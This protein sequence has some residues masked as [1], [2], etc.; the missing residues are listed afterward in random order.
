MESKEAQERDRKQYQQA[1][2]PFA[3]GALSSYAEWHQQH[4]KQLRSRALWQQYFKQIDVF[5]VPCSFTVAIHHDHKE[6]HS[7][8][9]IDTPDGR[10]PYTQ[11]LPWMV[12]ASLTGCPATIAPVGRTGAGLPVGIQIM[13]P[14]WEDATPIQFAD[15]LGREIG[16][17]EPPPGYEVPENPMHDAIIVGARCAGAPLAMLLSRKGHRVLLI[18]KASFPSDRISTHFIMQ[19]GLARVKRWGLL[20]KIR[21]LG[22][23]PLRRGRM[24]AGDCEFLGYPPPISGIDYGLAPRRTRLD[25]LLID[26]AVCSG[27][28]LREGFHVDGVLTGANRVTGVYGRSRGGSRIAEHA[29]IVVGADGPASVIA[30]TICACK[31][32]EQLSA[33]GAYY[34]YWGGAPP[35][36]DFEMYVRHGYGGVMFPTNDGLTC[37]VGGWRDEAFGPKRSPA[38]AYRAFMQAIPRLS[39]VLS[40][41]KQIEPLKG[42]Q[43]L[44]GYFRQSWGPGWALAGDAEYHKHPISAQGINRRLSRRRVTGGCHWHRSHRTCRNGPGT[45][46]MSTGS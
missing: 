35:V 1:A 31:Y 40:S 36:Q 14:F 43:A 12:T 28:E 3:T 39:E 13:G 6:D 18:D 17:F 46:A 15:L 23:P 24:D 45:I 8:R 5:L 37:I 27:A 44:H 16:G 26:E 22:A 25:K 29:R 2:S 41:G 21:A 19:A 4:L 30:R 20:E 38:D 9:S 42:M 34:S 32:N 33:G 10:R 11:L 7:T